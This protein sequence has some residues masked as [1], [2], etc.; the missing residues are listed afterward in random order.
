MKGRVAVV[1]GSSRGI[2]KAIA[3]ALAREGAFVVVNYHSNRDLA[4]RVVSEIRGRG[5]DAVAVGA[6]VSNPGEVEKM[7]DRVH[8]VAG[9]VGILVNNAGIHRHLKSWEMSLEEWRRVLAVNLDGVFN[10]SRAFVPDMISMR[11]GRMVNISSVVALTG[12]DREMHYAASKGGVEAATRSLAL[13]LAPYN[14][15]VNAIAPGY[16]DTDMVSFS[17]EEEREECMGRIPLGRMAHPS[18]IAEAAVFLCADES[19]Y[20]TGHVLHVNGGLAMR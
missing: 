8:D 9:D 14:V 7:R 15:R 17:S 6:D 12:T 18:E 4:R 16:V 1:T 5:G 2:G 10:C 11:W 19:S 20:I 3:L 13:E